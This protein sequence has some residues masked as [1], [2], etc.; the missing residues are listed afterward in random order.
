MKKNGEPT[1]LDN[2]PTL[3]DNVEVWFFKS[4]QKIKSLSSGERNINIIDFTYYFN[5]YPIPFSKIFIISIVKDI[6]RLVDQYNAKIEKAKS[7]DS[8]K[9]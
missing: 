2:V 7:T 1:P 9:K 6:D 8:M 3:N 5:I 4:Y